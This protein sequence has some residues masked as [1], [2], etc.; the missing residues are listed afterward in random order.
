MISVGPFEVSD[1]LEGYRLTS[2]MKH[3]DVAVA[4]VD[5]KTLVYLSGTTDGG[6]PI[7][8]L[9]ADGRFNALGGASEGM[10]N[11]DGLS[12]LVTHRGKNF[13]LMADPSSSW[14]ASYRIVKSGDHAGELRF[15]DLVGNK[16]GYDFEYVQDVVPFKIE[17]SP[18]FAVT[19]AET[20]S[21]FA[22]E[23]NGDMSFAASVDYSEVP[24]LEQIVGAT[25]L[26]IGDQTLLFTHWVKGGGGSKS[27][28]GIV[29]FAMDADGV[30]SQLSK[31]EIPGRSELA[32]LSVL[33]AG[34]TDY[35]VGYDSRNDRF[36]VY[37]SDAA[38]V[39]GEV[40]SLD[41][42]PGFFDLGA[43]EVI[44]L[45]GIQMLAVIDQD[46]NALRLYG[47]GADGTLSLAQE[48]VD[49][50]YGEAADGLNFAEVEGHSF[51]LSDGGGWPH[52]DI[53]MFSMEIGGGKDLLKG[54]AGDD[55]LLGLAGND[56]LFGL[57]GKDLLKGG[58]GRDVLKGGAGADDLWGG[59]WAD[60]LFGGNG[61]DLLQGGL[62]ADL[63]VG[64]NGKDTA[65]YAGSSAAVEVNLGTGL[66]EGGDARGDILRTIENL[67]GSNYKDVLVGDDG[68]NSLEGGRGKDQLEG[69]GGNDRLE[70]GGGNDQL[71]GGTGDDTLLAGVGRDRLEGGAG[72]DVLIAGKEDGF[73]GGDLLFGG[74]G[75]DILISGSGFDTAKGGAGADTFV[76]DDDSL[77]LK[78]RD[79]TPGKDKVDFSD[80]GSLNR[81]KQVTKVLEDGG[82]GAF[83]LAEGKM[84]K[85]MGVEAADL[86]ADDFLF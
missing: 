86:A 13:L 84:I 11:E 4:D 42:D 67:I 10:P 3:R 52:E 9:D 35:L 82:D 80:F 44:E 71:L 6:T 47:I 58:I 29:S 53:A 75:D 5:G 34:G 45:D 79:F 25:A 77:Y 56:R 54:A 68:A 2:T 37:Q 81:F 18:Y 30:P 23:T 66:G 28:S 26:Q 70:G 15:G 83:I 31:M 16:D 32:K 38:G 69:K 50:T 74:R 36:L 63:M 43:V 24:E 7:F 39:L 64:G 61:A 12:T 49:E 14:V 76:F 48:L 19:G 46:D 22:L 21:V 60:R 40:S 17:G 27:T 20:L 33:S 78:I 72:D 65:S 73:D 59:N 55:V 62:G 57:G 85:F 41:L 8:E 1:V 51:L